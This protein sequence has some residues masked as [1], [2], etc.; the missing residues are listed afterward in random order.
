MIETVDSFQGKQ[1]DVVILSCVRA[2][3]PPRAVPPDAANR[4]GIAGGAL[5]L[6]SRGADAGPAGATGGKARG[7]VGFLADVRRM[8]VAIT[9]SKAAL[10]ILG[11]AATLTRNPVWA[12]LLDDARARGVLIDDASGRCAPCHACPLG[13]T[14]S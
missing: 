9:R 5:E 12:A 8:N 1:L 11:S 3:K 7:G 10:W 14:P 13:S 4:P 6:N 2:G